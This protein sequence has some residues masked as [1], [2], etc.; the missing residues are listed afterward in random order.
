MEDINEPKQFPD[1]PMPGDQVA[2][3][4]N[5]N[6]LIDENILAFDDEHHEH[7]QDHL[8]APQQENGE[9]LEDPAAGDSFNKFQLWCGSR[10]ISPY[11]AT[12]GDILDYLLLKYDEG[13]KVNSIAT[14]KTAISATLPHIEGKSVGNHPRVIDFFKGLY[15]MHP[16]MYKQSPEWRLEDVLDK[17][18]LRKAYDT[19]AQA[20]YQRYVCT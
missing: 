18:D 5:E 12:I 17:I 15:N 13:L 10:G 1:N 4:E 6:L 7:V 9:I 2:V 8:I 11:H 3:N 20:G 16:K 14:I 19:P